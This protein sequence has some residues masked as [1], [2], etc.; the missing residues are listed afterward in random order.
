[1]QNLIIKIMQ[2]KHPNISIQ[3]AQERLDETE[4]QTK[5]VECP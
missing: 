2:Q 1:M 3:H 4:G 5:P